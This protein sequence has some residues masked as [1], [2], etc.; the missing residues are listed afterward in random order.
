MHRINHNHTTNVEVRKPRQLAITSSKFLHKS[1]SSCFIGK[2]LV[3]MYVSQLFFMTAR[4]KSWSYNINIMGMGIKEQE[5]GLP[6]VWKAAAVAPSDFW[7]QQRWQ[8]NVWLWEPKPP[9]LWAAG[10]SHI[11]QTKM[12]RTNRPIG[13]RVVRT[14]NP[15]IYSRSNSLTGT[16][17]NRCTWSP[18]CSFGPGMIPSSKRFPVRYLSN[19]LGLQNRTGVMT[20]RK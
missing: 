1:F 17:M 2:C 9:S 5:N 8:K 19:I 10:L 7:I 20:D 6:L 11:T 18:V 14:V 13:Y 4:G 3:L 15:N 12:T 16:R